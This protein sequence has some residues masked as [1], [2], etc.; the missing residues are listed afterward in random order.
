MAD[1]AVCLGGV[2]VLIPPK[3]GP[4]PAGFTC[5]LTPPYRLSM[6]F[7][8]YAVKWTEGAFDVNSQRM[9]TFTGF[10]MMESES[11]EKVGRETVALVEARRAAQAA[12]GKAQEAEFIHEPPVCEFE[13]NGWDISS[14]TNGARKYLEG[15]NAGIAFMRSI[16]GVVPRTASTPTDR[17]PAQTPLGI[18]MSCTSRS[19]LRLALIRSRSLHPR[20]RQWLQLW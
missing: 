5:S 18:Q 13:V 2:R 7:V 15:W 1:Q 14:S 3:T 17:P 12:E 10:G 8:I 9:G 16:D 4:Q 19:T 11:Y 6:K 20:C